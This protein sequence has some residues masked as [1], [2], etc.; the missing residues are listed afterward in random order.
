MF[1]LPGGHGW[2][3]RDSP[4]VSHYHEQMLNDLTSWLNHF[5]GPKEDA[6]RVACIGNSI[7]D[8][9]GIGMAP[10]QG[11]SCRFAEEVG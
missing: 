10:D 3:F 4:Q 2:G 5:Q 1:I 8:G 9:F 6:V 7:T 11:I